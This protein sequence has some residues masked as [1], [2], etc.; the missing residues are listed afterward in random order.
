[1]SSAPLISPALVSVVIP[2]RDRSSLLAR[3]L[4]SVLDQQGVDLRVIVVDDA[5]SDDTP[6]MLARVGDDRLTVI[7]HTTPGGVSAA[8][9][10]GI[11][12][13]TGDWVAFLDDDDLWSPTKLKAQIE[14]ADSTERVWAFSGSITFTEDGTMFFGE[15]PPPVDVI[16]ASLRMRNCVPAGASNVVVRTS[17]LRQSG[18]FD[19]SLRHLADWDLWI[20]LVRLGPPAP[21]PFEGRL[22]NMAVEGSA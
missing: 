1:Y 2:T 5:S 14:A 7:R 4:H 9:N 8:R 16:V 6:A 20:R 19:P 15:A 10:A 3:T 13:S 11:E 21:S 22:N 18:G 12:A 17:A